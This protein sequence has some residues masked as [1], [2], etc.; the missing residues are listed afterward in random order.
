M[1]RLVQE[2]ARDRHDEQGEQA[3]RDDT[4]LAWVAIGKATVQLHGLV[5]DSLLDQTI[6]LSESLWYWDDVL[7]SYANTLLYTVQIGPKLI[8][9]SAQET[10]TIYKEK[11]HNSQGVREAAQNA[12]QSIQERWR[13]FYAL[14]RNSVQERSLA[15]AS[16]RILSPFSMRQLEA[17]KNQTEITRLR[18]TNATA[19]GL[20]AVEGLS[21]HP[22]QYERGERSPA[23]HKLQWQSTIAKSV[24]LLENVVRNATNAE[25]TLGEFEECIFSAVD[26]DPEYV[27]LSSEDES[28]TEPSKLAKRILH[29]IDDH[30]PQQENEYVKTSNEY[31]KPSRLVRYWIPGVALILSGSTLLRVFANRKAEIL[32]WL[33]DFGATVQDFWLNWVIEPTRRL[34]GTIRHDQDSEIAI[35][36]KESLK[37][38][39]ESLE[40]MVVDFAVEHPENGTKYSDAEIDV[41]RLKVKEGDLTPVLKAYEREMQSPIKNVVMGDLVRTL[42]IQVQKTKVDVEV[43]IG[44]IDSLLK[45]QELLFGFVGIAPGVLISYFVV[46]WLRGTFGGRRGIRQ[47]KQQGEAV[48]TLRNIDRTL[49]DST[50]TDSGIMSYKDYGLLLCEGYVL[51]RRAAKV[52]PGSVQREFLEDFNDLM[53]IR[54]GIARQSRALA[55]IQWAYSQYL[56]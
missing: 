54:R 35:Q 43:A 23:L 20:I 51:R 45:S 15:R 22:S 13:D 19:I 8:L 11:V 52:I 26:A 38:D 29:I 34:I 18:E 7:G 2:L 47:K 31:G 14:V 33:Q 40:R 53:D 42:L 17:R 27:A 10:Y 1:R 4:D 56:R 9:K 24:S 3:L 49:T 6:P 44:G 36:S 5:L 16:R 21:F 25:A 32:Q 12:Q 41:I 28:T 37:A 30:L 55:R 48:R 50:P 39:K 46:Q